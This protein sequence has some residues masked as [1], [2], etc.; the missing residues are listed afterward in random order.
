MRDNSMLFIGVIGG[1]PCSPEEADLAE[2]VGRALA[3]K[4]AYLVCGGQGGVMEAACKGCRLEGGTTI[5]ILPGEDRKSGNKYVHIPIV[6]GMGSARNIIVAKSSQ[7]VIAVGGSYGTLSEIGF[8]LKN[9]IPVIGLNSWSISRHN[10]TDSS[11][12]IMEDPEEAVDLA[13]SL[14]SN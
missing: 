3:K 2:R 8:A 13:I 10:Q 4:G 11:I 5:G 14:A 12:I 1:S 9:G 7:A 6:T